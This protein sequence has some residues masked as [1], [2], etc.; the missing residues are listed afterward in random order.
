VNN[1]LVEESIPQYIVSRS[2]KQQSS[3]F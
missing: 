2:K 1:K 3:I